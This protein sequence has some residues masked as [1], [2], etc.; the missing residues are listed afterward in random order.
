MPVYYRARLAMLKNLMLSG[1]LEL[2][3]TGKGVLEVEIP[4]VL[5]DAV[6]A[7]YEGLILRRDGYAYEDGKRSRGLVKI[8]QWEDDEYKVIDIIASR[9]GYGVLVCEMKN[10]IRFRVTAPG[11]F[12]EKEY[13]LINKLNYIGKFVNV[14]YA[15][16]TENGKPFHP[17][18]TMW[19]NKGDE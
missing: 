12:A 16:L 19:R 1:R 9:D 4:V 5:R 8:K 3:A 10:K 15:E 14:Q 2:A 7:G 11:D 6:D 18:A 17:I 13:V